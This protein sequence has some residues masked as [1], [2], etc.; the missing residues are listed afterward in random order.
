MITVNYHRFINC[1]HD[2]ARYK[3]EVLDRLPKQQDEVY[4]RLPIY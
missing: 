2:A 4:L 1:I 3:E